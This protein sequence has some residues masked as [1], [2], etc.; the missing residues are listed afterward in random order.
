[1]KTSKLG[2][3][4][5]KG[6]EGYVSTAYRCP[7]G[8]WTIGYGHTNGVLEGMTCS[9]IQALRWLSE[10]LLVAENAVNGLHLKINQNQFDAL[11]SFVYNLGAADLYNSTLL[12]KIKANAN[13]PSIR[14]EFEKWDYGDGRV[15]SG[16]VTRRKDEANL[17]FSN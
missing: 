9:P 14:D 6:A 11:V 17:Y 3:Q 16:L 13:D 5:I 15:L 1:M 10:D 8:I 2:I 7:A 12:K 4:L